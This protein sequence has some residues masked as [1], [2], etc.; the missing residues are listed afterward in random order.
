MNLQLQCSI[1]FVLSI[2]F[3]FRFLLLFVFSKSVLHRGETRSENATIY[4]SVL[5]HN[6]SDEYCRI[7]LR[8]IH[9]NLKASRRRQIS[10]LCLYRASPNEILHFLADAAR[11]ITT[12]NIMKSTITIS[13]NSVEK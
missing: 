1:H 12:H 5:P 4:V 9:P 13:F 6:A 8:Y 10:N 11:I 7:Y 3:S 2:E